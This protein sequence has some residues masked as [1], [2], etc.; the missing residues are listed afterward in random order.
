MSTTSSVDLSSLLQALYGS[1]S[2]GI[3]VSS[4]VSSAITSARAPET[5]WENQQSTITS[6]ESAISS[7]ESDLSSLSDDLSSLTDSSGAL[8]SMTTSSSNSSAVS[9]SATSS[10]SAGTHTV[11]VSNLASIAS[12]YSGSVASSST[13]L[14]TGSFQ[15]QVGS[16]SATTITVDSSDNTLSG[17]ASAIN[18]KD[19][20]V[21]ASVVTDSSGARLAIVA[22]SSGGASDISITNDTTD[23]GALQFTQAT[24]G[25]NASLTVDGIPI[26][27]ASNTVSGVITGVTLS[28][29][30]T[31]SSAVDVTVA[32]DTDKI[33]SV[34]SSF[35]SDYNTIISSLSSEF[36]YDSTSSSS[37]VLA[38][39]ST[40]RQ[41]QSDLLSAI[42][43][44]GSSSTTTLASLGISMNN[45]GTLS[46][47]TSTL[48]SE[49]QNNFSDVKTFLQGTS[50]NGFANQLYNT[51]QNYTDT[52][53]GA[54]TLDLQSL[55]SEYSDLQNQIDNFET[56][57]ITPLQTTLTNDYNAAEE[58][59]LEMPSQREELNN[60]L[61]YNTSSN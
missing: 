45:D 28:L 48:D 59:L 6:Q 47:D 11:T 2:I 53:D 25:K 9:A 18:N 22:N 32:N 29:T 20:G 17:L 14:S 26:S 55:K 15:L 16:G 33:S 41:L 19:L 43:Y 61:G 23:S 13:T 1:S 51:V 12:W 36:T 35:V 24:Q 60:E 10:A 50:S 42:G 46:L 8:G 5:A 3:D 44:T 7:L 37:G 58:A 56:N 30:G 21:T 40:V 52:T 34:L 4:A 27:S 39:D 57:Y 38:Q 49:L 31:S 54:F